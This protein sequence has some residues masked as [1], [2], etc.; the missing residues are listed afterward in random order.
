MK[1]RSVRAWRTGGLTLASLVMAA[2][3]AGCGRT[4]ARP[5]APVGGSLG[6]ASEAIFGSPNFAV[7]AAQDLGGAEYARRD[8]ALNPRVEGPLLASNQWPEASRTTLER[9]R[10]VTVESSASTFIFFLPPHQ[11]TLRR[12]FLRGGYR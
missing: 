9:R 6:Q 7:W 2:A 11:S 3:L 12:D 10:S 4:V 8:A 1:A 5:D